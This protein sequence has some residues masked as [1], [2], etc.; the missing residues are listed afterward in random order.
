MKY[1]RKLIETVIPVDKINAG[2]AHEK[3]VHSAHPSTLHLWWSR[4]PL[5]VARAVLFAQC[6]NDP[7]DCPDLFPTPEA[8][9]R[10]RLRLLQLA[11]R[12][13]Q[14]Q[15]SQDRELLDEARGRVWA[16]WR[17]ICARFHAE[18]DPDLRDR[19]EELFNPD[20]LPAVHDPFAGGGS[21]PIEARRL[22]FEA[23]ASDLNP[24]A[25]LINRFMLEVPPR[26]AGRPPVNPKSRSRLHD[27]AWRGAAG[28]AEDLRYYAGRVVEE[29][30]A[31]VGRYYPPYRITAELA[32]ERPD[33]AHLVGREVK[34]LAWIWTRTVPSANPAV[35]EPVPLATS[36]LLSRKDP[37]AYIEPVVENGT[38]RFT[39]RTGRTEDP[40]IVNG[41]R[42]GRGA[43]R[44]LVSGVPI[45]IDHVRNEAR[46]GRLGARLMAVVTENP[47]GRG[48]LYL[49]P[50]PE[51]EAA[52]TVPP[53]PW[54]P[55][56]YLTGKL[57]IST[58]LYGLSRFCDLFTPRQL[59]TLT[60]LSNQIRA[61]MEEVQAD[62]QAAYPEHRD[63]R[64]FMEGGAGARAYAQAIATGLAFVLDKCCD[65][66]SS[67]AIWDINRVMIAHT[68]GRQALQMVWDYAEADP[69]GAGSG[70]FTVA[71]KHV[72]DWLE[73]DP[74][75]PAGYARQADAATQ[76]ISKGKIIS[77]DPPY[78][79]NVQYADLSDFF[80][81]W[82]RPTLRDVHPDLLATLATPK[83]EEIV[84]APE[85]H[86]GEERARDFF[87]EA[88][89][90]AM[91]RLAEQAHPA[92][93][94]TLYYAY[95]QSE[96]DA[97]DGKDP[98]PEEVK[99]L[100]AAPATAEASTGW[101][102]FL[103][104]L[105]EAGFTI[106][107]TWPMRT[108]AARR[109]NAQDTNALASSIV[110]ACRRRDPNA[111]TADRREFLRRLREEL[112]QA[113]ARMR[114]AA[115][116]PVDFAQAAIGPG[117]AVYTRYREVREPNGQRISVR[118]ALKLINHV[119]D[120]ALAEEDSDF[121]AETRWAVSWFEQHRFG[122]G[123]FGDAE[124]LAKARNVSVGGLVDAGI[125]TAERG[126][127]RLIPPLEL[128]AD[129]DPKN[130]TH[131]P[132]WEAL[133]HLIRAHQKGGDEGA[134]RLLRAAGSRAANARD[135]AYRLYNICERKKWWNE[136]LLYNALIQEWL[137]I[138]RLA[139]EDGGKLSE[140]QQLL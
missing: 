61:V 137:E 76:E 47:G 110:L 56:E 109:L 43:F 98:D 42:V 39:V 31:Q 111:P 114:E 129:W 93:P 22:G 58:P 105:V 12:L 49:P 63:P 100:D 96:T 95:K 75:G 87:L 45:P 83:E 121:D 35:R 11:E 103:E 85:R 1:P 44:C 28:L 78:Y 10:E 88:M 21:I 140:Q 126:R 101:E 118:N 9:Q 113:L 72:T 40:A 117:M 20:R 92:F 19:V 128:P 14:W 125:L 60:T 24:V 30:R 122:E 73:A 3:K 37:G 124:I 62:W 66:N 138:A 120:Q 23:W 104:S 27:D 74:G 15:N 81:V 17:Y 130:D 132:D 36:F 64:P 119:L 6:V 41:T 53:P 107:A 77:T 57:K 134:A 71:L 115:I 38:Y 136:G 69:L 68:F 29:A 99:D 90:R 59:L 123:P 34:P 79:D 70:G 46:A 25:T 18:P 112:P 86:G 67:L 127:V 48:K 80:Y 97:A 7:E 2:G 102:V 131:L 91:R 133:H 32:A 50:T 13:A 8:Q 33:L 52:A 139:R 89:T 116:A 106:T 51:Q 55:E 4:K 135:L 16:S 108:E 54:Q 5:T 94:V 26:F 65:R 82:L 84:A